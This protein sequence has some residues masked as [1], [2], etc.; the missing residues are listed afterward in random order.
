MGEGG[1]DFPSSFGREK[2]SGLSMN[3]NIIGFGM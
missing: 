1:D 3:E 2:E